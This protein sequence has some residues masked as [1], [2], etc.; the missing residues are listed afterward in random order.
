MAFHDVQ[1]NEDIERGAQG[2]PRFKT[3]V[4]VLSSGF[5]KR[6]ID[7]E[8]SRGAWDISYGLDKKSNL[9]IVIAFFYTRNGRAHSF[10]FK[11]WTDFQIGIEATD[12]PQA[13]FVADGVLKNFQIVRRYASGAFTFDRAITR[14]VAGTV[15]VFLDAAEQFSGFTV[16][17]TT[18]VVT[19]TVA[20]T[21]S[22][23]V[24]VICEFD[25]PARFDTDELDLRAFRDDAFSFPALEIVEVRETLVVLT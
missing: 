23:V 24:G 20:P 18:G 16:D 21:V 10:R 4:L 6:N 11:D 15:R 8:R 17:D 19:F 7:W 9:E 25:V 2:G 1:L 13:I 14:P 22:V 3:T 5:E 12:T